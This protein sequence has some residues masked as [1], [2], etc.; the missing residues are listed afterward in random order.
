MAMLLQT[1]NLTKSFGG[2]NAVDKV[3]YDLEAG[4]LAGIIGPNGSGK[5]TFVN[6]LSGALQATTGKIIFNGEDITSLPAHERVRLR[7]GRIFQLTNIFK[8][9]TVLQNVMVALVREHQADFKKFMLTPFDQ[10]RSLL[11]EA[12]TVLRHTNLWA[13]K[14][15]VAANLPH[16][17]QRRL[18]MA[19]CLATKPNLLL[20]DEPM[21]GLTG[22]EMEQ[23]L[24]FVSQDLKAHHTII[25]IE[26][27]L[28][29]LMRIADR[30]TVMK[31]GKIIADGLPQEV[32]RS[33]AAQEAY[34]GSFKE[35]GGA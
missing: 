18:E 22:E 24:N 20:L 23:M 33:P 2:L 12:E 1:R 30:I 11:E 7:I 10:Q 25:M 31:E 14:D 8:R 16:G 26:H 28:E 27:R 19:L 6:L 5:T 9:L 4:T 17:S 15:S 13:E 32:R 29:G 3:D 21:A 35:T 34:L